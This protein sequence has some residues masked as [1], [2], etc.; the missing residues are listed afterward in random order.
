MV[1]FRSQ[2]IE[3]GKN[4]CRAHTRLSTIIISN[5]HY[6]IPMFE[7]NF[8]E[9]EKHVYCNFSPHSFFFLYFISFI[10]IFLP[11]FVVNITDSIR[12]YN[13]IPCVICNEKYSI[14]ILIRTFVLLGMFSNIRN[15]MLLFMD[16]YDLLFDNEC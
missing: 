14:C 13:F 15:S 4:M 2:C 11:A 9:A 3:N 8:S 12:I 7:R 1:I 10:R 5:T 6:L 16:F